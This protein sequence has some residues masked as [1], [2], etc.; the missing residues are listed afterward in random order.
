MTRDRILVEVAGKGFF[1]LRKYH[2]RKWPFLYSVACEYN[3][4]SGNAV[5]MKS[6]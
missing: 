4:T 2:R 6:E 3:I 1:K 5:A